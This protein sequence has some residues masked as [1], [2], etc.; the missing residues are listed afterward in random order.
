MNRTLLTVLLLSFG[1]ILL[2]GFTKFP[3][4]SEGSENQGPA[5]EK[6]EKF[7]PALSH[8][9]TINDLVN[10]IDTT[11]TGDKKS[12]AFVNHMAE[13]IMNRFFHTYSYYSNQDNWIAALAG[14][15]VWDDLSAIV[16]PDDIMK[17]PH[18]ACSQQTIV[19]MECA[20]RCGLDYRKVTFDHHFAAEIKSEGRWH[21]VDV[22][23]EVASMGQSVEDLVKSKTLLA[24]YMGK[25]EKGTENYVLSNPATGTV[26]AVEGKKA[27]LFQ[28][29]TNLLST[30]FF[31]LLVLL[32]SIIFYFYCL[33]NKP[34]ELF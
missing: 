30:Y 21:Y 23:L 14:N 17:H 6:K 18:A 25:L 15:F 7:S 3:D 8:L 28:V 31:A 19:L 24:M 32:Q 34:V 16:V 12:T 26:N 13:V 33:R 22:N 11:Y 27:K 2:P 29:T 4:L 10:F 9:R 20:K 5:I 1:F